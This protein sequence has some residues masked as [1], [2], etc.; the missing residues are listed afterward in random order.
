[1]VKLSFKKTSE[2]IQEGLKSLAEKSIELGSDETAIIKAKDIIIDERVRA[3]CRY[4]P[5][6]GYGSSI[7]CPPHSMSAEQTRK[8]VK[9][10]KHAIIVRVDISPEDAAGLEARKRKAY[11]PHFAKIREIINQLEGDAFHQG[12]YLALGFAVGSCRLCSP[13][14]DPIECEALKTNICKFPF[15]ARPAMESVGIDVY[16]TVSKIGWE[17]YPV[18]ILSDPSKI[19]CARAFGLL[20][21][22]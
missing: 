12:F 17:I 16:A 10:Y 21:V 2:E 20:L 22:M 7:M 6:P 3:K 19:P 1:L 11:Y 13:Q 8:L 14:S 4:P 9:L 15:K 18:G 5:C